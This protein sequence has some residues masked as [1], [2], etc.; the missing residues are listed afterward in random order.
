[1]RPLLKKPSLDPGELKNSRPVSNL[2]L[3]SKLLKQVVQ[4]QLQTFLDHPDAMPSHQLAYRR[5]HST[6]T[7]LTKRLNDLLLVANYGEASALHLLD[8]TA[9]FDTVDH[10]LLLKHLKCEFG[11]VSRSMTFCNFLKSEVCPLCPARLSPWPH[12]FAIYG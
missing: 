12:V 9:G 5:W 3:V 7:E 8:L 10:D 2:P 11:V 1:M 6:E 4:S